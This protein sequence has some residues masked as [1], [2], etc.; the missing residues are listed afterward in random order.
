M[1]IGGRINLARKAAGFNMRSLA[2]MVGVSA[3]AISKYETG[4][5]IPGS[6]VLIRLAEALG[7]SVDFFL[8]PVN[9]PVQIQ[10]FRKRTSLRVKEQ[11][12]IE[13]RIQE[14]VER[15]LTVESFFPEFQSPPEPPAY[16]V[17]SID[18]VEEAAMEL[19]KDWNLGL[20]A[21]E[22][23]IQLIE[24]QGIKVCQVDGYS[25][26]DACVF[27]ANDFPVIAVKSGLLGDRQRFS[28]A[29]ELG[30]IVL[31]V[32]EGLDEEKLCQ[33]FAGAFLIPAPTLKRELGLNRS[34]LNIRELGLLKQKYG[35]SM[36]AI[37]YRAC[38]LGIIS[39]S[40]RESLFKH[41]S[42]QHWR[43]QEPGEPFPEEHPTRM[44]LLV[45]RAYA[46]DLISRSRAQ[47][48][49]G[50]FFDLESLGENGSIN[51]IGD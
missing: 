2:G 49:L 13:M 41:F 16:P 14:I 27:Y 28:L 7:V 5:D 47:E 11:T 42:T 30:H 20:D 26:F 8:R 48:L 25:N 12:A 51:H 31:Q 4:K 40:D 37:I 33:R 46:E 19:R 23:L 38:D 44:Q 50:N 43:I 32:P 36:Q 45:Y 3:N 15:Y 9:T 24:D 21:I 35:V 22:N 39:H 1:N 17:L 18:A 6:R 29:H 34:S 10:A